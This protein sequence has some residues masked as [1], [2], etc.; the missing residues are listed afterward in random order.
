MPRPARH[1]PTRHLRS[2]HAWQARARAHRRGNIRHNPQPPRSFT[3]LRLSSES[4]RWRAGHLRRY[5]RGHLL[6]RLAHPG[7]D[8]LDARRGCAGHYAPDNVDILVRATVRGCRST[9]LA[10][11]RGDG[12]LPVKTRKGG[13][14]RCIRTLPRLATGTTPS[15][16][17]ST[18]KPLV[19]KQHIDPADRPTPRGPLRVN[20]KPP[21]EGA[22]VPMGPGLAPPLI[23]LGGTS[24]HVID[25]DLPPRPQDDPHKPTKRVQARAPGQLRPRRRMPRVAGTPRSRNHELHAREHEAIKCP[26]RRRAV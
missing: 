21:R 20:L 12:S 7:H 22:A 10:Q 9:Y 25:E 11:Q 17:S 4:S 24:T 16:T 19:R 2:R 18:H 14:P 15:H 23:P 8:H 6:L 26:P 3:P 5:R 13:T 1:R